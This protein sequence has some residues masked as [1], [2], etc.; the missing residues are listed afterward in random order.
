M[1]I[2]FV[3]HGH[4]DYTEP[5][6][7]GYPG[8]G[9]D[10]APLDALGRS[11]A[12]QTARDPRLKQ[13]Q[14]IVAS[15]FTRALQTA[16]VLSHRLDLELRVEVGLHEWLPDLTY[17]YTDVETVE[18]AR[19]EF[20]AMNGVAGPERKQAWETWEQMRTR[21]ERALARYA[22]YDCLIVVCHGLLMQAVGAEKTISN[23]GIFEAEWSP[24]CRD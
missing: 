6:A 22:G 19:A 24:A 10:L 15:P 4:P 14:L 8:F 11:Q 5:K 1:K 13:G 18:R 21:A 12:E 16:A 23:G 20:D 17:S 7:L 2:F 9:N 3:R